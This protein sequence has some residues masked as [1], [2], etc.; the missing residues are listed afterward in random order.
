MYKGNIEELSKPTSK[1]IKRARDQEGYHESN[2]NQD[3]TG[4]N[5]VIYGTTIGNQIQFLKMS[6]KKTKHLR[7]E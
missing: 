1:E 2:S 5:K 4:C 7:E 3:S 6:F